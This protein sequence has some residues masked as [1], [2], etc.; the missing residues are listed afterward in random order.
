Q[1][2][3]V[4]Q[5]R[6]LTLANLQITGGNGGITCNGFGRC[7]G[8]LYNDKGTVNVVN[9]GFSGNTAGRN[10]PTWI[11][12][13]GGAIYNRGT[14]NIS[15]SAFAG[16]YATASGGAI[17]C[18]DLTASLTITDSSFAGNTI[19]P[20]RNGFGGAINTHGIV[21]ITRSTFR[22]NQ[23]KL[24]QGGAINTTLESPS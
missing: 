17:D 13:Q 16:N 9:V 7:G 23:A 19:D 11:A 18:G 1:I 3:Y 12:G 21:N 15:N 24:G 8:A 14:L 5:G 10:S 2:L 6:M 4:N 22:D 20:D